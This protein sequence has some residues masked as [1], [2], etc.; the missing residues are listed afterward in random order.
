MAPGGDPWE[1]TLAL[2]TAQRDEFRLPTTNARLSLTIEL[3]APP[4]D[5]V[6]SA[7][8]RPS[9]LTQLL[10]DPVRVASVSFTA[11]F[12]WWLTRSGG[13]LTTMLMGIPAWRHVD[14]LPVLAQPVDAP[15]DDADDSVGRSRHGGS[16]EADD[17]DDRVSVLFDE[18][19]TLAPVEEL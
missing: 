14:L 6:A 16:D 8:D 5:G 15:D 9:G 19:T 18:P 3:D 7:D 17:D 4:S 2:D 1:F 12:I 10:Q 11:G 13:L